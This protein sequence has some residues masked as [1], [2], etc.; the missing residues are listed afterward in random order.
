MT[1]GDEL[2][3]Y[4][5]WLQVI[6]VSETERESLT[7]IR[8]ELIEAKTNKS[9]QISIIIMGI[10]QNILQG[11]EY[12][13]PTQ[14]VGVSKFLRNIIKR[15]QV[16]KIE[17]ERIKLATIEIYIRLL[18]PE[19]NYDLQ[20]SDVNRV[21]RQVWGRENYS[22]DIPEIIYERVC[23]SLEGGEFREYCNSNGLIKYFTKKHAQVEESLILYNS[24]GPIRRFSRNR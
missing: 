24:G 12:L 22:I 13:I 4:N 5:H 8:K 15:K 23:F 20:I 11:V 7:R 14:G 18:D 6:E 10:V 2:T 9:S 1:N 19:L 17:E 3:I 16:E 21:C